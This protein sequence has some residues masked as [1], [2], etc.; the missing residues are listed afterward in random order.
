MMFCDVMYIDPHEANLLVRPNPKHPSKPQIVLLDHGLYRELQPDF[1]REYTR[2]WQGILLGAEDK[3]KQHS[4]AMNSGDLYS[5]LA[6]MLTLKP[7]DEVAG[8]ETDLDRLQA[9]NTQ[10]EKLMVQSY[11]Y[12]YMHE[13]LALMRTVPS[14][15]LLV[16][17]TNDCLR[18]LD[19]ILHTPINSTAGNANPHHLFLSCLFILCLLFVVALSHTQSL[20]KWWR[21]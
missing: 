13:I 11:C 20:L 18:H 7:W 14:D 16:F 21:K 17:K 12:L 5:L 4:Q 1:R 3:I 2:L 8:M 19:R 9:K 10:G 6:A 15:L